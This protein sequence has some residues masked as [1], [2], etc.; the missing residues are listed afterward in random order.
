MSISIPILVKHA[1]TIDDCEVFKSGLRSNGSR[2]KPAYQSIFWQPQNLLDFQPV[3]KFAFYIVA[4]RIGLF[5]YF[6]QLGRNNETP[7]Q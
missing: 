6:L 3:F 5:L 1:V 7:D 4:K 2:I